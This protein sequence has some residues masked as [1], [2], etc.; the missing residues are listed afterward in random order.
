MEWNGASE[1]IISLLY[2]TICLRRVCVCFLF[3]SITAGGYLCTHIDAFRWYCTFVWLLCFILAV[4]L[5]MIEI[6][7]VCSFWIFF[8]EKFD[9]L[10]NVFNACACVCV[11]LVKKKTARLILVSYFDKKKNN[12]IKA[13]YYMSLV[14]FFFS[15]L[16]SFLFSLLLKSSKIL[17]GSFRLLIFFC[18]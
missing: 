7:F 15:F 4:M 9:Y 1:I 16:F 17:L 5:I 2:I 13:F 12:N 14:V 18:F 3:E 10:L 6:L 8:A 11:C